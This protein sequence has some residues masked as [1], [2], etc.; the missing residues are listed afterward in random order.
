MRKR[1]EGVGP[2]RL[3]SEASQVLRKRNFERLSERRLQEA[4]LAITR[5]SSLSSPYNYRYSR[6][7]AH[8]IVNEID[9]ALCELKSSFNSG[10]EELERLADRRRI[11]AKKLKSKNSR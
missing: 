2:G 3:G 7:E 11:V 4:I 10:L 6:S 5:L 8:Q 1:I 9:Q